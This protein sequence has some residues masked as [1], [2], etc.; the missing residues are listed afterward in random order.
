MTGTYKTREY[1]TI[2]HILQN[3][4]CHPTILDKTLTSFN[5]KQHTQQDTREEKQKQY[6]WATFTYVGKQT[7]FISKLFKNTNIKIAYR[8]QTPLDNY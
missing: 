3:N 5:A 7:T 2:R 8:T 1:N 4:K 6:K